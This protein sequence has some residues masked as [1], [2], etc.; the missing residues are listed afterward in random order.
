MNVRCLIL[1]LGLSGMSLAGQP[2]VLRYDEKDPMQR[3]AAADLSA[4]LQEHGHETKKNGVGFYIRF[5]IYNQGFGPQAFRI[6]KEGTRGYSVTGGDSVGVMYGGLEL[7]EQIQLAGDLGGIKE[8]ARKP[9]VPLRGL[10]FN[11]PLDARCPSYDDTG[12]AA[13]MNIPVVWEW[14]FWKEFIDHMIRNRYNV[15]TLWTTHPFPSLVELPEYPDVNYDDVHVLTKPVDDS[16]GRL[17]H[18]EHIDLMDPA[19]TTQVKEISLQEK[20]AFWQRVFTYAKDHGIDIHIFFWNLYTFGAEG[21]YG[22]T[23]KLENEKTKEYYRYCIGRFLETYPQIDG[24]GVAAGEHF[25]KS[26]PKTEW[27]KWLWDVYGQGINEYH[28]GNPSRKIT[29]IFRSTGGVK[30]EWIEEN[31]KDYKAGPIH[32]DHK[33]ARA[34]VH[35]T[36]TSPWLDI[37]SRNGLEKSKMPCWLNLR[38]DDLFVLRWGDPDYVREFMANLPRDVMRWEAG[39]FLGPDGYVQGR[40]FCFKDKNSRLSGQLEVDKHWYRFMMFGRL[41]YDV[42]LPRSYFE[43]RLESRYPTA[44][45]DQLYVTWQVSSKIIPLLNRFSFHGND[46]L[47]TAESCMDVFVGFKNVDKC[48]FQ[49]P[50]LSNSDMMGVIE[51]AKALVN[52]EPITAKITPFEV[53]DDLD[54]YA[55]QTL[56]GVERLRADAKG[57]Q[58]KSV[59]LDLEAMAHLGR[60]YADKI[61]GAA[62]LAIYRIDRNRINAHERAVAAMNAAVSDW[63]AYA[64]A[65]TAQYTPQLYARSGWLDWWKLLEKVKEEVYYVKMQKN[66]DW[67]EE[68]LEKKN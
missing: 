23:D 3:F 28:E 49:V 40:E 21:H 32:T 52:S 48:Y 38:N 50:P 53:A 27:Y 64:K 58:L 11:I 30:T 56:D 2:V 59:L 22:I 33:Y 62:E 63:E 55:Q 65:A 43:Q 60:Y 9:Y 1:L 8:M 29:F 26:I 36:T 37:Q 61:R 10:K 47:F 45:P 39:Y 6:Q 14:E 18:W 54:A 57:E 34:R 66:K 16:Y 19:N 46:A 17:R 67:T 15:L 24:L 7:A 44:D 12:T 25:D 68:S 4:A 5:Q 13:H 42:T 20:I 35:S 41:G 51:Y 31:F